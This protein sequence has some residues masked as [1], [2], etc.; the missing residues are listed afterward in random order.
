ML[1]AQASS[2]ARVES[3]Q[4]S[5]I[6]APNDELRSRSRLRWSEESIQWTLGE[7]S[8]HRNG[9]RAAATA[10]RNESCFL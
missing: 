3:N 1:G 6:N 8:T 9:T 7:K 5:C 4:L 2:P 10:N